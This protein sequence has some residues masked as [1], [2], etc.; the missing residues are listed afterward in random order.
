[1]KKHGKHIGNVGRYMCFR[2]LNINPMKIQVLTTIA[3]FLEYIDLGHTGISVQNKEQ[4]VAFQTSQ[5]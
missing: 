5:H 4:I 1:M 2:G 3:T